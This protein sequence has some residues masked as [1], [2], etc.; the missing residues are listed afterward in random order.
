MAGTIGLNDGPYLVM[1]IALE[2]QCLVLDDRLEARIPRLVITPNDS[3]AIAEFLTSPP[4]RKTEDP[5][6]LELL[7]LPVS[8]TVS[9]SAYGKRFNIV[10][11]QTVDGNTCTVES[12]EF[13]V[14]A[15][16]TSYAELFF[17]AVIDELESHS[18]IQG[19]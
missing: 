12:S 11:E 17:T 16:F 9:S 6:I 5:E 15:W 13:S 1:T 14:K 2:N 10:F 7:E 3:L 4:H 8:L 18:D 19:H